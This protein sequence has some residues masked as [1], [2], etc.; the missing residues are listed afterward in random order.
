MFSLSRFVSFS[1]CLLKHYTAN[2]HGA[3]LYSISLVALGND[4]KRD[5]LAVTRVSRDS[6]EI[7]LLVLR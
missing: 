7:C 2:E 5:L 3:R 6:E 1:F 4:V